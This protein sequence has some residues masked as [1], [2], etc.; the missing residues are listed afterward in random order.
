MST[1]V[2]TPK[3][4]KSGDRVRHMFGEIA[5]RYDFMNH[6]LS[7]NIDRHWRR[8]AVR[9]A[10]PEG[11]WPLLDLCTGT[12][13][14]AFAYAKAAEPGT[15]IV[16]ADFCPEMLRIAREKADDRS[17]GKGIS[18]IEADAMQLPFE[19]EK[20]QLVSVAFG[21][22]NIADT[23][24]GLSEMTRVCRPRGRVV[25]LEFSMPQRQPMRGA[26]CW[27]FRHVLPK[28]GAL[29]TKS[30]MAAYSYLP[31][32]VGEFPSG[33]ALARRM[34]DVGLRE[35]TYRPLTFGIATLYVGKK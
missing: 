25:V 32:S 5:G 13:D 26:Y 21:L 24:R 7:M 20:F 4:D 14:L 1:E 12:G 3:V 8:Q 6:L 10:P 31:E 9:F 19:D 29:L 34:E 16:G 17:M 27:Y 2:E 35:V 11:D 28:L 23:D 22:R 33:E 18:F 30:R 15:Q